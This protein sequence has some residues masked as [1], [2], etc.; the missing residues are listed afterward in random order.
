[1]KH[2][3]ALLSALLISVAPCGATTHDYGGGYPA[4][5]FGGPGGLNDNLR[6]GSVLCGK[7]IGA[8][9]NTT[10]D[11]SIPITNW[12]AI[13]S[14]Y[15]LTFAIVKNASV[16]LTTAA[17]GFYTG[18]GKT[19]IAVIPAATTYSA[20]TSTTVNTLANITNVRG[21]FVWLNVTTLFFALTTP[22]GAPATA[23]IYLYCSFLPAT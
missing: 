21:A 16:S 11:Q 22:Q 1:M 14:D 19:G 4:A 17:G 7:L 9:F 8:N 10:A 3:L 2:L 6:S 23:D 12:S 5:G 18:A 15:F 20:I 13:A